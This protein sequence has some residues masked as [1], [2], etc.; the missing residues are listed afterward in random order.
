MR[1]KDIELPPAPGDLRIVQ[2]FLNT[3]DLRTG[4]DE[5]ASPRALAD[6]LAKH[7]LIPAGTELTATDAKRVIGFREGLRAFL[8]AGAGTGRRQIAALD[9]AVAGAL[10]RPRFTAAGGLSFAPAAEGAD[11]AV[12]HLL[13]IFAAARGEGLLPLFKVCASTTCRQAFYDYSTNHSG[14]WCRPRCGNLLSARAS[15]RRQQRRGA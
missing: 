13:A 5:L 8:I 4:T 11:G 9:A 6:W 14:K 10:L 1:R 12:A 7:R 2:A 15:R 3:V